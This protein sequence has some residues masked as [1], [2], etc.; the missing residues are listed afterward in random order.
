MLDKT[1]SVGQ[2]PILC[3]FTYGY[4]YKSLSDSLPVGTSLTGD[5]ADD[6]RVVFGGRQSDR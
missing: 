3:C 6:L 1:L 5:A 4:D 2:G